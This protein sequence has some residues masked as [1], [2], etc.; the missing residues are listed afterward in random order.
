M[1]TAHLNEVLEATG[2]LVNGQPAPG[3]HLGDEAK[4]MYYRGREFFPDALW[5][6]DSALTVYFKL[7]HEDPSD[8]EVAKWRQEI[9]NQGFAPLLWV[10]SPDRI[11]LYNCF[12]TPQQ[13]GDAATHLL[14][15]FERVGS[16]LN[17]LDALAGRL[18]MET[19]Q[20]WQQDTGVSRK[21]GVARRLLSDLAALE[22]DLIQQDLEPLNAQGLI[23]R[24]IFTQ[25][26]IDRDIITAQFLS[27]EYGHDRL[28]RIL[29]DRIATE[30]LFKWLRDVFNGDMFPTEASRVPGEKHLRRVAD[31]LDAT[32]PVSQQTSLFPYQFDVIPV[33]LISSIYEQF[34]RSAPEAHQGGHSSDVHYTRLSLVSLVLDEITEGL[35]GH[36][37]VC[38]LA[39][40]SGIFLV[41]AFRKLVRAKS[42]DGVPTRALI[43]STLH[44]QVYGVDISEAAVRVAAFSL[45]LAAL[46]LDQ[47]PQPA[48]ELKFEPLIGKNLIVA[49]A[50]N[51][52]QSRLGRAALTDGGTPR[53][54]E[55]ILGNPPWS[56]Q[57]KETTAAHRVR[58]TPNTPSPPRGES[59]RFALRALDFAADDARIGLVLSGAQFFSRST[60]GVSAAAWLIEKL[61]PV[62]LVNLSHH[63]NWLF[64]E[65]KMPA[66]VL[67]RKHPSPSPPAITAVQ[68]PWSPV[69]S[70]C[71]AFHISPSDIITV[72]LADWKRKPVLEKTELLKAAFF[73][74]RRDLALLER[75]VAN[76]SSLNER[77]G[78]ISSE[79]SM[80]MKRGDRS[81]DSSS[82]QGL[83][84]LAKGDLQSLSS[85]TNLAIY[86]EPRA[87][88][89]RRLQVYRAPLLVVKEVSR[90]DARPI[91]S[92]LRND[93]VFTDAFFGASLPSRLDLAYLLSGIL[94]SSITSWFLLMTASSYGLW[95]R[96]ILL[97][98]IKRLPVPDLDVALESES[99]SRLTKFVQDLGPAPPSQNDW[100]E[101]DNLVF[102]LYGLDRFER[103]IMRD[104]LCRANWQWEPGRRSSVAAAD[105][106]P[107]LFEYARTFVE[108]ISV[109]LSTTPQLNM[110]SQIFDLPKVTPLRIVRFIL[111]D[112]S[113]PPEPEVVAPEGGLKD[114]LYRIGDRLNVQLS[115]HLFGQRELRVYGSDEVVIIKPAARRH[116]MGVSALEDA[117]AVIAESLVQSIQ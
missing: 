15:S 17:R 64:P 23:G 52:E 40:G 67:L 63:T 78:D 92:V 22:Q 113:A 35:T 41:E 104:G 73:G 72:P 99:G 89:P 4:D 12:G 66:I 44:Q 97:R 9:W 88:R 98:D 54:F 58:N 68:V 80:G 39:C 30:H 6:G 46:E 112:G 110:R 65:S 83:P 31:F 16:E 101:L 102:D 61:A 48:H 45:Y 85:P 60:T 103:T 34:A 96:R 49:D 24:S 107:D 27:D 106:V 8:D 56:Y 11:N 13:T 117:D 38:D 2:Y 109:W 43:R 75:L 108:A 91:A 19:G 84:L 5:R 116:W 28:S 18:A 115:Q 10:V 79:L 105:V 20:F 51:V 37:T 82:L 47:D 111:E 74:G 29:R 53:K 62:T 86:T 71:Y 42:N 81:K 76:H 70:S 100:L 21:T 59:L 33:E 69:A 57:G 50:W 32:D 94:S 3:V 90:L 55:V 26:L 36:E 77:L 7:T 1:S 87:E 25:Y 114:V 93:T 14:R 95:K